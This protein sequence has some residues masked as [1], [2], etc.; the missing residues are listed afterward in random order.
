MDWTDK[1]Y[2]REETVSYEAKKETKDLRQAGIE[3]FAVCGDSGSEDAATEAGSSVPVTAL[4][5]TYFS[6]MLSPSMPWRIWILPAR[7]Q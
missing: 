6:R 5:F 3:P 2:K 1:I 7:V 4:P